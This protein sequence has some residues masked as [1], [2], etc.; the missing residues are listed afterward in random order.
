MAEKVLSLSEIDAEIERLNSM[1][2]AAEWRE[3]QAAMVRNHA[4]A[5]EVTDR[6]V[7]D[8]RKLEDLGYLPP[9]LKAALTDQ[10]D[11][12]NPGMYIKKPKAPRA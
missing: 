3:H 6:L 9:K 7:A 1:R 12:F 8:I 5:V 4:E 10:N 2:H 11:K